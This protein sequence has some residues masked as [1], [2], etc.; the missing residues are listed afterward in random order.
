MIRIVHIITGLSADGA[1]TMLF[2]IIS[3]MDRERFENIV[4]SLSD[5]GIIGSRIKAGGFRLFCIGMRSFFQ[6]P[7]VL[8]K[9]AAIIR[10]IKPDIIQGWMYHGNIAALAAA[11]LSGSIPVVWNIRGSHYIL[12]NEKSGTAAVI[13]LS[14][15]L[16]GLPVRIINNSNNSAAGHD[17]YLGYN[18]KNTVII[19]NGFDTERFIPSDDARKE[20]RAQ[21]GIPPDSLIIGLIGRFHPVKD[22]AGFIKAAALFAHKVPGVFFLMAGQGVTPQNGE[23]KRFISESGFEERFIL[24]GERNDVEKLNASLDIAV[25]SSLGEGFPNAIGEAM[26][27]GVPCV[28]TEV[29]DSAHIVGDTGISVPARSPGELSEAMIK[30]CRL[31]AT[32]RRVLGYSARERIMRNFSLSEVVRRYEA[33]YNEVLVQKP[34]AGTKIHPGV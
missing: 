17:K 34:G 8:W 14:A 13:W 19:P 24:L 12:R 28:V 23:L 11:A 31:E 10:K 16:S 22:H 2:R 1:Q 21:L 6:S 26:S 3:C 18:S 27:C 4:I 9:L 15:K 29:G 25:N 7:Q 32:E 5:E 30:I 33:L 20:I